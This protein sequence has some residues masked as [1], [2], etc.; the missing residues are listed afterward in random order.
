M[1][2]RRRIAPRST[3]LRGPRKPTVIGWYRFYCG[4][5]TLV[6]LALLVFSVV[7]MREMNATLTAEQQARAPSPALLII[8]TLPAV[9]LFGLSFVAGRK[10]W[11]WVLGIVLI[12]IG[13]TGCCLPVCIW[14][15]IAWLRPDVKEYF[16]RA[17]PVR[18]G[19]A[20]VRTSPRQRPPRRGSRRRRPRR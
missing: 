6:Y 15:L 20:A 17:V 2:S 3:R 1:S 12:C 8:V 11:G 5:L 7:F 18:R 4:A 13:F 10:P 9:V 19:T 14:M 16:G